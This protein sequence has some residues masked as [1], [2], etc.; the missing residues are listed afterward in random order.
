MTPPRPLLTVRTAL[1]FLIAL[2]IG[3]IASALAY[4]AHRSIPTAALI[5]ASSASGGLV[6]VHSMLERQ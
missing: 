6:L 5:G 2:V 4:A 3:L 1:V